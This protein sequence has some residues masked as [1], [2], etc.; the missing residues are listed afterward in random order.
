MILFGKLFFVML[1]ILFN[2]QIDVYFDRYKRFNLK[3][4]R[5][6]KNYIH[7]DSRWITRL[8]FCCRHNFFLKSCNNSIQIRSLPLNRHFIPFLFSFNDLHFIGHL[9]TTQINFHKFPMSICFIAYMN[10]FMWTWF[11][12]CQIA[13]ESF[14]S[15]SF[16]FLFN[17]SHFYN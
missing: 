11:F 8:L 15:F 3:F 2:I 16:F 6:L 1:L 13:K 10:H 17:C 12:F 9:C 7:L 5:Q 14:L 4:N